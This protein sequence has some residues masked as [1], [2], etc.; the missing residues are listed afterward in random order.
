MNTNEYTWKNGIQFSSNIKLQTNRPVPENAIL[1]DLYDGHRYRVQAIYPAKPTDK[2]WNFLP[3]T[4]IHTFPAGSL[5]EEELRD[6]RKRAEYTLNE[7]CGPLGD[8]V[9]FL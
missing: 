2:G 9:F 8:V 5:S 6:L 1:I 4:V 7:F 3:D